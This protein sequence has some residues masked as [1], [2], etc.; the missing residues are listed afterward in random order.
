MVKNDRFHKDFSTLAQLITV[1]EN[2]IFR[3]F[4]TFQ[5]FEILSFKSEMAQRH[6]FLVRTALVR[7]YFSDLIQHVTD[8]IN[9]T[10]LISSEKYK[11]V[12]CID[13]NFDFLTKI[14]V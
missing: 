9:R 5:S 10:V 6:D 13:Q 14:H 8:W 11:Q 7:R 2:M 3:F 1:V 12:P 4:S